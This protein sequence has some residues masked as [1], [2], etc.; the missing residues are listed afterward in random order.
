M[1]MYT[2]IYTPCSADVYFMKPMKKN[3]SVKE[4]N[5]SLSIF[6]SKK[7]DMEGLT[8]FPG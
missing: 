4:A 8:H 6:P 3:V 7:K 2:Q 5:Y 1:T